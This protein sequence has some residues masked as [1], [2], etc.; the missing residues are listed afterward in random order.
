LRADAL[1]G[2]CVAATAHDV[3]ARVKASTILTARSSAEMGH[4]RTAG[5]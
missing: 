1:D 5:E 3:A 2:N 4:G